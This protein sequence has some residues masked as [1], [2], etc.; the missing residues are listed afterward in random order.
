M[1]REFLEGRGWLVQWPRPWETP[2]AFRARLGICAQTLDRALKHKRRPPVALDRGAKG[3]LR[4]LAATA[5]FEEFCLRFKKG[6][7]EA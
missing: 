2:I 3:R 1:C 5:A 4:E 7:S 6:E